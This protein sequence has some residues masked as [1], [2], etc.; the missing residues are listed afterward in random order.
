MTHRGH[1]NTESRFTQAAALLGQAAAGSPVPQWRVIAD[2]IR[3]DIIDGRAAPG[4]QF[5]N[6]SVLAQRFQVNRHTLRQAMQAL[7]REGFVQV[8]HGKGTTVRELV[9]DYALG[10]RTRMSE[11]LADAGERGLRELLS[12]Q[13][14]AAGDWAALLRVTPDSPIQLLQTRASV[15]GRPISLSTNAFPLPRLA[16]IAEAFETARSVTVAMRSLGIA[17]YTRARSVVSARLP[18]QF[19]ADALARPLL[20]PVLVVRYC[21]VDAQGV[22]VEA[23]VSVFAADA[24]QFTVS[25]DDFNEP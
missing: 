1:R 6:E 10:R 2:Q 21:N 8:R 18:D 7:M 23:G 14:S 11:N 15:R 4:T 25:P 12:Q 3:D 24:V 16:G 13:Q 19:E 5:P 22:P 17:D 9:L 20:Q